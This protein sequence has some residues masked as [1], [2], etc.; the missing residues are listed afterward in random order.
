L[1]STIPLLLALAAIASFFVEPA[2]AVEQ[3]TTLL[4]DYLPRGAGEIESTVQQALDRA[5]SIG[6][7]STLAFL[8]TGSRVFG[9]VTKALNIAYDVDDTYSFVKRTMVE[10]AMLLTIGL[11]LV[12][13][14]A[15]RY[16]LSTLLSQSGLPVSWTLVTDALSTGLLLIAFFLI[17][18][19]LPRRV[20]SW[21]AALAGSVTAIALFLLARPLFI[22]YVNQ[23]A[24]YRDI[25]GSLAIVVILVFWAWIVGVIMIF[26][27]EVASHTEA[28]LIE[29]EPGDVVEDRHRQR[30][31]V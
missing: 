31:P 23:F 15:S 8:W 1:L 13:A 27:G 12:A 18:R 20:V 2:Q 17:Y 28:M 24:S 5:G 14:L 19:F 7:I 11:F 22:R 25:Y 10:L 6:L 3:A 4:R 16:I 29:R 30:S 26:G 21:Q 9:V